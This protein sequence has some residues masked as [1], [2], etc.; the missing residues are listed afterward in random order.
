[1]KKLMIVGLVAAIG[2]V[3]LIG[4]AEAAGSADFCHTRGAM[5][6]CIDPTPPASGGP[7]TGPSPHHWRQPGHNFRH[8]H[9]RG[10]NGFFFG[11]GAPLPPFVQDRGLCQDIALQLQ[12]QGFNH[13][14]PLKC[15]GRTY[16]YS[17]WRNGKKL[18]LYVT[19]FNGRIRKIT[20]AY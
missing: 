20:P 4:R 19:A 2:A 5:G 6:Q 9:W 3:A 15:S 7:G 14:R 1:M 12:D 11:F 16:I 10:Q 18:N 8:N 13:L 17:A